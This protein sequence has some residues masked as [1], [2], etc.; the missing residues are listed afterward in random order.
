MRMSP[1]DGGNSYYVDDIRRARALTKYELPP[2]KGD[3]LTEGG[4]SYSVDD[5]RGGRALTW[6]ELPP[7]MRMSPFWIARPRSLSVWSTAAA[8]TMSQSVRGGLRL[9][10]RR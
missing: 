8:G 10:T 5:I 4:N 2:S 9:V 6:Y 3:N 1:F 7:S